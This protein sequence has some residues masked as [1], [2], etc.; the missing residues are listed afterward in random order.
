MF[1]GSVS[2]RT[3]GA[4]TGTGIRKGDPCVPETQTLSDSTGPLHKGRSPALGEGVG[5]G[6]KVKFSYCRI[7]STRTPNL[8]LL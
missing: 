8:A 5:L 1:K 7:P 3:S 2:L 6:L 4:S